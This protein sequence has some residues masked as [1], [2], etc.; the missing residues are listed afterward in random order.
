MNR[1]SEL[2][3]LTRLTRRREYDDGLMDFV[4]GITFLFISLA[5]WFF[6][7]SVGL[8][9]FISSLIQNR[10]LTLIGLITLIPLLILI[11]AGARR[12]VE[13]IRRNSLWKNRGFVKSL[14]WQISWQINVFSGVVLIAMIALAAW[15][16]SQGTVNQDFVLRT[17]VSALGVATS[18]VFFGMGKD[19]GLRRYVWVGL[20]GGLLSALISIA[21][22]S[23]SISWFVL[24]S[25]WMIILTISG[26]WALQKSLLAL[27]EQESE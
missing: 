4:F 15:L 17:L 19:L 7:S 20:A 25:L 14:S 13:R 3:K 10:E 24:G 12:L 23:F 22:I 18:I 1:V 27:K 2:D 8:T 5:G 9:W 6:F 21:P 26:L 16:L 11:I